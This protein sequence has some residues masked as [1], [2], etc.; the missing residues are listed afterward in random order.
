MQGAAHKHV[1]GDRDRLEQVFLNLISNAVKY[2]P[3]ADTVALRITTSQE[4]VIIRV[5]DFGV[6][7]T[8]DT[9]AKYL[10]DSIG[11][12]TRQ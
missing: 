11:S 12:L 2:S 1:L 6:G 3:Q 4:K 8:K 9:R 10:S 7:I 5:Q